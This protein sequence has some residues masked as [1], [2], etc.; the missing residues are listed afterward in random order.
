MAEAGTHMPQLRK[1]AFTFPSADG[2]ST[3]HAFIVWPESAPKAIFLIVHGMAE[4][5]S[6]YEGFAEYLAEAGYVVAGHDQIGHGESA[7][8]ERWGKLPLEN[9]DRYLVDDI[10][11][12][13][14]EMQKRAGRLPVALFGHSLGSYLVRA[15]LASYHDPALRCAIICGTGHVAPA[16]S[17]F[18]NALAHQLART[19]G[20]DATT[21]LLHNM[22][23]GS[24][25]KAVKGARTEFDWLSFS[26]KNVDDYLADPACGFPFSIGGYATVTALTRFVC[27]PDC[28]SAWKKDVPVLFIAG[29]EDPVGSCGKGVETAA[30]MARD[31]GVEDV[32]VRLLSHMRHEI[33]NEDGAADAMRDILVWTKQKLGV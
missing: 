22:A 23:D 12:L 7:R 9:G 33:L 17:A 25:S 3:I 30:Q 26:Q 28:F 32:A 10:H 21:P 27:T 20:P 15:Y 14:A 2:T 18:G 4:H 11:R 29:A 1:E 13:F 5:I 24:Y 8:P 16:A 19:K 31:A 6:R